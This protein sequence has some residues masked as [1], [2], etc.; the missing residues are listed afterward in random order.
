VATSTASKAES[1]GHFTASAESGEI[2][3][4]GKR[5]V[6]LPALGFLRLHLV[7]LRLEARGES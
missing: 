2:S 7:Y 5:S 6:E 4:I 3:G 1:I